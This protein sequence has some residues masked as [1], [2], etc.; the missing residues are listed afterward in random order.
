MSISKSLKETQKIVEK[1]LSKL[2]GGETA[3]VVALSGDLGAGKTAFVKLSAEYFG[4]KETITSPTFVIEK[5]YKLKNQKFSHLVHIDA[6]RLESGEELLHLGFSEILK[7]SG[8]IIF[9]EWSERV[10]DILPKN[11]LNIKMKFVDETTRLIE[12][13]NPKL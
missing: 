11:I 13:L 3:T 12:I 9:I 8:N 2:I 6:Y 4:V 10:E 1:F 5:I 7:D